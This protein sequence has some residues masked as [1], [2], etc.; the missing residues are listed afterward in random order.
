M[1]FHLLDRERRDL[2]V[3][4]PLLAD[5][6]CAHGGH[7]GDAR[8]VVKI[9]RVDDADPRTSLVRLPYVEVGVVR[10]ST[11]SGAQD[12]RTDCEGIQIGEG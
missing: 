6:G 4:Q 5:Q 9:H 2:R 7:H 12:P 10:V 8:I 11:P 3:R 1:L